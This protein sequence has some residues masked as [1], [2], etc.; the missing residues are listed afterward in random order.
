MSQLNDL[1]LRYQTDKSSKYHNY[2][3]IYESYLKGF[4]DSKI[5]LIEIGVGG[6]ANP[7]VG[8]HSLRMWYDY[9]R[10]GKIIGVD[11]YAKTGLINDRTEFWQGDQT[12]E[13]LL[14]VIFSRNED[15][16]I[17]VIIDDAS[18]IN[19]LT[20]RTF[21]ILF[22]L[23]KSG[24]LYFIEDVHT[25]YWHE[26]YGGGEIPGATGTAMEFFTTLTHQLNYET[27]QP[28]YRNEFAGKIEFIHFYKEII[29]VKKL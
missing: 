12:D 16:D 11:L 6:E 27:I 4:K 29:V 24:D 20:I 28:E 7:D 5:A 1:A 13:H 3:G 26:N 14:N 22:P 8:G 21:K 23:L 9:F 2:C 17:R 18:H 15:A 10:K 19:K 25:S